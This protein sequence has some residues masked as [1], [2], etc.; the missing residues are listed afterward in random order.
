MQINQRPCPKRMLIHD[1]HFSVL[2]S[3][4]AFQIKRGGNIHFYCSDGKIVVDST[5]L[6]VFSKLLSQIFLDVPYDEVASSSTKSFK[7]Y[8]IILPDVPKSHVSH[9]VNLVTLGESRFSVIKLSAIETISDV[10][11][12]VLSTADLLDINIAN[13]GFGLEDDTARV[14]KQEREYNELSQDHVKMEITEEVDSKEGDLSGIIDN[15]VENDSKVNEEILISDEDTANEN[16]EG[17]SSKPK[18]P[19]VMDKKRWSEE[20]KRMTKTQIIPIN[21]NGKQPLVPRKTKTTYP[22]PKSNCGEYFDNLSSL[23]KHQLDQHWPGLIKSLGKTNKKEVRCSLCKK[24]CAKNVMGAHMLGY[25]WKKKLSVPCSLCGDM[26]SDLEM[27]YLHMG[28]HVE[29]RRLSRMI[30]KRIQKLPAIV[31]S[32]SKT[33]GAPALSGPVF[34]PSHLGLPITTVE[35]SSTWLGSDLLSSTGQAAS[36]SPLQSDFVQRLDQ[37]GYFDSQ[38]HK[39]WM[40]TVTSDIPPERTATASKVPKSDDFSPYPFGRPKNPTCQ[41]KPVFGKSLSLLKSKSNETSKSQTN[42]D[43]SSD[44]SSSFRFNFYN[45]GPE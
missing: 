41:D 31:S 26:F 40:S 10:I 38:E 18:D 44:Q 4:L 8:T 23:N 2:Q 39:R 14:P 19:K 12:E 17:D 21:N 24:M 35:N 9:L 25:H 28:R 22:C 37:R 34:D 11:N 16:D 27:L 13:Y 36:C 7:E 20:E 15:S 6:K 30:A 3:A 5:H 33:N 42:K 45:K 32:D 29:E 43:S 1:D